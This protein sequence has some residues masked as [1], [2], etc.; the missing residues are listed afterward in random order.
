MQR[1]PKYDSEEKRFVLSPFGDDLERL[2]FLTLTDKEYHSIFR[3]EAIITDKL[4]QMHCNKTKISDN[5]LDNDQY[6]NPMHGGA[7]GEFRR[8]I[9]REIKFE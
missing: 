1:W 3:Y 9:N 6:Y 5:L 7:L 4:R 2:S 8:E